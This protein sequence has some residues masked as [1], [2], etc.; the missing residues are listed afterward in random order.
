MNDKQYAFKKDTEDPLKFFRNA[1]YHT[2]NEIYLDGNSLGKLPLKAKENLVTAVTEEWGKTLISSWNFHWLDRPN[3]IASKYARLL[4]LNSDEIIIGESTSIRLYQVIYALLQSKQFSNLLGTDS[5]Q[6][7]S[8]LYILEGIAKNESI[9]MSVISY[10]Q[11]NH[12]ELKLLKKRIKDKPGIYCLSLVSYKSGYRYP[13]KLLNQWALKHNSIIVW[14]FSHAIGAITIDCKET[15][16]LIAVGCTYKYMNGGPGSPAFLYVH[17]K[18][19]SLLSNPIKGWFGHR[20]PFTFSS[21]F[22]PSQTIERF[23]VGT[24]SILSLTAIEAGVDLILEAGI[25]AIEQKS[26]SQSN[27]FISL[28]EA[29]LLPIGFTLETPLHPYERGSHV[30]ISHKDAWPICQALL[31]E[32]V[33]GVKIIPDFR[34]PHFIRFGITPLYTQYIDLWDTVQQLIFIVSSNTYKNYSDDQPVVT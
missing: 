15:K 4:N 24:P 20:S 25:K 10:S 16:T 26:I 1:F 2:P 18:L 29:Q 13:L 32:K 11:E 23:G 22:N 28:I 3:Q 8:D 5:L 31:D 12:A 6:F 34:P 17:K 21:Q 33:R 19:I 30:S 14:D 27:Y 9:E 7:P